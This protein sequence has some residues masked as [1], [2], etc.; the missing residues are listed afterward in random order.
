MPTYETQKKGLPIGPKFLGIFGL[1][2]FI[3]LALGIL[4]LTLTANYDG[5]AVIWLPAGSALVALVF[6]EMRLWPS[7]ALASLVS[8]LYFGSSIQAAVGI[9]VRS[10]LGAMIATLALRS[11]G[12]WGYLS[13]FYNALKL[14]TFG[15]VIRAAISPAI[16]VASLYFAGIVPISDFAKNWARWVL[17]D[18]VGIFLFSSFVL[19]YCMLWGHENNKVE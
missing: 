13:I 6:I 7:V 19:I 14:G 5:V 17:G 2:F 1:Y 18:S 11:L 4:S 3:S 16:G 15:A 12:P 10:A 9:G 8:N